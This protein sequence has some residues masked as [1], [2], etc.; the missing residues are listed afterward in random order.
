M[1]FS[2]VFLS[3]VPALI[4]AACH[5]SQQ[6]TDWHALEIGSQ[7]FVLLPCG[8][9][10]SDA[11][12]ALIVAGGKR[13][14]IGAPAG[15]ARTMR[16]VDL[17][18]LDAV[19]VL[20]LRA[21]DLEGLDEVRNRSWHIGRREP[22]PTIGPSGIEDVVAALNLTFEQADALHMVEQ[23]SPPGGYDAAILVA[24]TAPTNA[25]IFDTGDFKVSRLKGGVLVDYEGVSVWLSACSGAAPLSDGETGSISLSVGCADEGADLSWPLR[26]PVFIPAVMSR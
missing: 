14:L 19:L 7:D 16:P 13:V 23:G 11:A 26:T 24:R 9:V 1:V 21:H 3:L 10:Q 22:L 4:L 25:V 6:Q 15:I 20:S 17:R 8:S 12:C 2:R 18:Q 5:P